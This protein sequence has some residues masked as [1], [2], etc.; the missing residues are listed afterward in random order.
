MEIRRYSAP[1]SEGF[2]I[3]SNPPGANYRYRLEI[4]S[5]PTEE[6]DGRVRVIEREKTDDD[7]F[8]SELTPKKT[9]D[10][11]AEMGKRNFTVVV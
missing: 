5:H 11:E 4:E 2:V 3:T 8:W 9:D 1:D 6:D 7:G 10:V